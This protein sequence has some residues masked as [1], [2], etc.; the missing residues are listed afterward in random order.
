MAGNR[1]WLSCNETTG[2]EYAAAKNSLDGDGDEEGEGEEVQ[3]LVVVVVTHQRKRSPMKVG[4]FR[5]P[6]Q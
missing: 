1:S 5:A 6:S 4:L 3:V 2:K